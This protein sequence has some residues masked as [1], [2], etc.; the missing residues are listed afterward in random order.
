VPTWTDADLADEAAPDPDGV[1]SIAE[2]SIAETSIAE[3]SLADDT[4]AEDTDVLVPAIEPEGVADRNNHEE[5]DS[6]SALA[7]EALGVSEDEALLDPAYREAAPGEDDPEGIIDDEQEG[8][9]AF[10]STKARD[11]RHGSRPR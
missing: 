3:T 6:P 2:T 1:S 10:I 5:H 11:R 8:A 7:P 9:S 4:I